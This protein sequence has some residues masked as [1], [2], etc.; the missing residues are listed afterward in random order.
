M[1]I[2]RFYFIYKIEFYSN[3]ICVK[4]SLGDLNLDSYFPYPTN[5]Y[6]YEVTAHGD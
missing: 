6:I 2:F 3:L 5:T 1:F 4:L